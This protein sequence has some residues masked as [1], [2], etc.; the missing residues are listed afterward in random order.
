[1]HCRHRLLHKY[2][3]GIKQFI[4]NGWEVDMIV[5]NSVSL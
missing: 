5:V 1:M 4:Y 2:V 3:K